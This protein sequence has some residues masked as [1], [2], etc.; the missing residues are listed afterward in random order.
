ML[1]PEWMLGGAIL[2]L[3]LGTLITGGMIWFNLQREKLLQ[4]T[5]IFRAD[6]ASWT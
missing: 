6:L 5:R 4:R 2:L 1:F 3:T